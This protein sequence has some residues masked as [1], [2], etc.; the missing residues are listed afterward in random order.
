M[1]QRE[2]LAAA[3]SAG[4]L[5]YRQVDPLL[6]FLLQR[7]V[8][9]KRQAMLTQSRFRSAGAKS[10][11]VLMAY[12]A[13]MLAMVTAALFAV[14]FTTRTAEVVGIGA[15]VIFSLFYGA[16]ALGLAS[17]FRHRGFS[18]PVRILTALVIALVPVALY[19][20]N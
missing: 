12:L 15:L 17:W 2:D 8:L 18:A 4:L 1:I 9:A 20:L 10:T 19:S 16:G 13:G 6:V 5:H 3:A 14:L 7:D 11:S